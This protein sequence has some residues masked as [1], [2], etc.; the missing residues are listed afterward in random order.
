MKVPAKSVT[1]RNSGLLLAA[2]A[3]DA[4]RRALAAAGRPELGAFLRGAKV[5]PGDCRYLT[6]NPA[7]NHEMA[8]YSGKVAAELVSAMA[9]FAPAPA[10]WKVRFS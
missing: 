5:S 2:V 7:A 4:A 6:G 10:G 3:C 8:L 1:K 9:P